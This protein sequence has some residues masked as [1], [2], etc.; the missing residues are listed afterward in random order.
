HPLGGHAHEDARRRD[1]RRRQH[2]E[3]AHRPPVAGW[4]HDLARLAVEDA[5]VRYDRWRAPVESDEFC[6]TAAPALTEHDRGAESL[7]LAELEALCESA[8]TP[9]VRLHCVS[10]LRRTPAHGSFKGWVCS[11]VAPAAVWVEVR[12]PHQPRRRR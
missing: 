5:P 3:L 7:N 12:P 11:R 1:L 9:R 4:E 2:N 8:L 10:P 6:P